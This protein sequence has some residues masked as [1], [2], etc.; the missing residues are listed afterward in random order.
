MRIENEYIIETVPIFSSYELKLLFDEITSEVFN[1]YSDLIAEYGF[2]MAPTNVVKNNSYDG[3]IT[4]VTPIKLKSGTIYICNH[5]FK[6]FDTQ[7][8]WLH[9]TH[10]NL[11][12]YEDY[13]FKKIKENNISPTNSWYFSYMNPGVVFPTH[14]D[15]KIS[16]LRY[17]HSVVQQE[18][19]TSFEY[20]GI[21]FFFPENSSYILNGEIP[22]SI[23]NNTTSSRLMYIG[24]IADIGGSTIIKEWLNK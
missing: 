6:R 4:K 11:E 19:S 23:V 16:R 5:E 22:H 20:N 18:T 12:K 14:V 17:L 21:P 10:N 7:F 8:E 9:F 15:G 13:T 2:L 1:E 24:T 3:E